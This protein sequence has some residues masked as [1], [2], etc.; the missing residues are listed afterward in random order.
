MRRRITAIAT[1]MSTMALATSLSIMG[2]GAA[3]A[4]STAPAFN[5]KS[6]DTELNHRYA[7]TPELGYS[8]Y[9]KLCKDHVTTGWYWSVAVY[10]VPPGNGMCAHGSVQW[11]NSSAVVDEDYGMYTCGTGTHGYFY[12]PV[13]NW[14]RY[15]YTAITGFNDGGVEEPSLPVN[16]SCPTSSVPWC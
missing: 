12:T 7:S 4:S 8:V 13:R 1:V 10:D 2:G 11:S 14:T 3:Y 9:G 15:Q 16:M 6:G 5:C